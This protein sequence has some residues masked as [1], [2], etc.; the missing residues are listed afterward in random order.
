M[1]LCSRLAVVMLV[2]L[3]GVAVPA[4]EFA[5]GDEESEEAAALAKQPARALAQQ[6]TALVLVRGDAGEAAM[7]LDAAVESKDK[8][9]I[10][11]AL[12]ERAMETLDDGDSNRAVTMLDEALSRPL[13][14]DSGKALHEAGREF[15]PATGAQEVVAI[16][17]GAAALSLGLLAL[18]AGRRG[19]RPG[20]AAS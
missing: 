8:S 6:A 18:R 5:H 4:G 2:L 9:D 20:P 12:L 16:A 14:S 7:R 13:G 11:S 15:R 17:A 19:P 3:A 1:N 10:D